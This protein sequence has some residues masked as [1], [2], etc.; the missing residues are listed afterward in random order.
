MILAESQAALPVCFV[1]ISPWPLSCFC[2]F[3]S[4][5]GAQQCHPTAPCLRW[6]KLCL[7]SSSQQKSRA[8]S[9]GSFNFFPTNSSPGFSHCCTTDSTADGLLQDRTQE[10]SSS[11]CRTPAPVSMASAVTSN[12]ITGLHPFFFNKFVIHLPPISHF[13]SLKYLLTKQETRLMLSRES[14]MRNEEHRS[15]MRV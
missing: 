9:K 8:L 3:P 13:S 10:M 1:F 4:P 15:L 14:H 12:Q 7:H 11:S 2:S 6:H 5:P